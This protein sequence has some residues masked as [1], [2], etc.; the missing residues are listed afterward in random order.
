MYH[1]CKY[2]CSS[3]IAETHYVCTYVCIT[4]IRM[5][6][7]LSYSLFSVQLR[8]VNSEAVS[9]ARPWM[10]HHPLPSQYSAVACVQELSSKCDQLKK[11]EECLN[12]QLATVSYLRMY[13][14]RTVRN[15]YLIMYVCS[16]WFEFL[17]LSLVALCRTYVRTYVCSLD[18]R[19]YVHTF[20]IGT[21]YTYVRMYI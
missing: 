11:S 19:T 6:L 17:C 14:Q 10:T 8:D 12:I 5:Y 20:M 9:T 18:V 21:H 15:P 3:W 4:Y 7:L 13:V 16:V 2:E 1:M